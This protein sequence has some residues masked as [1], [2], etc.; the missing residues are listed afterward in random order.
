ME[1]TT[2]DLIKARIDIGLMNIN[3]YGAMYHVDEFEDQESNIVI[4][5]NAYG[6]KY[7]LVKTHEE[8]SK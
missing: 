7:L 4:L 8:T 5:M 2:E 3:R 6:C 1:L